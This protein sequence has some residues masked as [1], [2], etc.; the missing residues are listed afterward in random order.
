MITYDYIF[1]FG[2]P[3]AESC[4]SEVASAIEI[5]EVFEGFFEVCEVIG[6]QEMPQYNLLKR[7]NPEAGLRITYGG[8]TLCES[9]MSPFQPMPRRTSFEL[10][11]ADKQ[12]DNFALVDLIAPE[13]VACD[14]VFRIKTPAGC[15]IAYQ[16]R[17]SIFWLISLSALG[18]VVIYLVGGCLYNR[19]KH[20]SEGLEALPNSEFWLELKEKVNSRFRRRGQGTSETSFKSSTYDSI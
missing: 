2:I 5:Y 7:R 17:M 10:V 8:G 20:G 15:P 1:N 4:T 14:A 11:C 3:L 19:Y 9:P 16:A 18:L 12:E 6:R 13:Y